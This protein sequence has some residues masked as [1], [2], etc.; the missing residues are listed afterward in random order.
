M[1]F[2]ILIGSAWG[3]HLFTQGKVDLAGEHGMQLLRSGDD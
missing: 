2:M 3:L 1:R